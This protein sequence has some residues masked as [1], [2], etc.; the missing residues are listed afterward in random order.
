MGFHIFKKTGY[1]TNEDI[2]KGAHDMEKHKAIP[3]FKKEEIYDLTYCT[4]QNWFP[5]SMYEEESGVYLFPHEKEIS[6][7]PTGAIDMNG[8]KTTLPNRTRNMEPF[9]FQRI[10]EEKLWN[11]KII[12]RLLSW[13]NHRSFE[14]IAMSIEDFHK[15]VKQ[16]SFEWVENINQLE[17]LVSHFEVVPVPKTFYIQSVIVLEFLDGYVMIDVLEWNKETR[18][19]WDNLLEDMHVLNDSHIPFIQQTIQTLQKQNAYYSSLE[20]KYEL[21]FK[22]T[23]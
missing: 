2:N 23:P 8:V 5:L 4:E 14:P 22:K 3:V 13:I 17:T 16:S 7:I 18:E 21:F 20:E 19:T 9:E 11:E 12:E 1:N 10:R 15:K 6:I